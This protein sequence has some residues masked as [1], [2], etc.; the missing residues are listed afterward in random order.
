MNPIPEAPAQYESWLLRL[1]QTTR[2]GRLICQIMLICLPSQETRYF[3]DLASM[4]AYLAQS[5]DAALTTENGGL[6]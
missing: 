2:D 5:T 1:R 4:T 3:A 6:R